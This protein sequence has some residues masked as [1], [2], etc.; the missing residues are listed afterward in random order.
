LQS[1]VLIYWLVIDV[2]GMSAC[3]ISRLSVASDT[4]FV[5]WV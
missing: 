1:R 5:V 4:F 2:S 3:S